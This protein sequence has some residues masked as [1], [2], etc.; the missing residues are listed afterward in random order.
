[1]FVV[2]LAS[3]TVNFTF[4]FFAA[5]SLAPRSS[6][7]Q[8]VFAEDARKTPMLIVFLLP[9]EA[10]ELSAAVI[11]AATTRMSAAVVSPFFIRVLLRGTGSRI[12]VHDWDTKRDAERIYGALGAKSS[13]VQRNPVRVLNRVHDPNLVP[14]SR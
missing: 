11:A 5:M 6:A 3:K 13:T 8:Y 12:P 9:P 2:N 4:G 1:M 7:S 14:E 10:V